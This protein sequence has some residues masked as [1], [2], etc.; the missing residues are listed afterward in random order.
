[1]DPMDFAKGVFILGF[2]AAILSFIWNVGLGIVGVIIDVVGWVYR[3]YKR[4]RG[5]DETDED[6][7]ET[8]EGTDE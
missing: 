4:V 5:L 6:T 8:D 7:E 1:M 3:A 2:M